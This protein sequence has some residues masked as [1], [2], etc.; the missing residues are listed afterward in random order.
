MLIINE[1]KIEE[2]DNYYSFLV[3]FKVEG[4]SFN[5]GLVELY[6][7]FGYVHKII[8]TREKPW[9]NGEG[10]G[11]LEPISVWVYGNCMMTTEEDGSMTFSEAFIKTDIVETLMVEIVKMK[12][13]P[14]FTVNV[15]REQYFCKLLKSLS[16]FWH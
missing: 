2:E 13:D 7:E 5:H 11:L 15:V 9:E 16:L 3:N 1:I 6:D 8:G 14:E 10:A 12:E 4:D